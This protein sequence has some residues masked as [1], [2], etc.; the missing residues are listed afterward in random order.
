MTRLTAERLREVIDCEVETIA[1]RQFVI[2]Y[3]DDRRR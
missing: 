1:E 3:D 2:V